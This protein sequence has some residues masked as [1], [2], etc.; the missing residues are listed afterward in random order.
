MVMRQVKARLIESRG[1]IQVA[2]IFCDRWDSVSFEEEHENSGAVV[3]LSLGPD[4]RPVQ[5]RP[6]WEANLEI[7]AVMLI[8]IVII[9]R[10]EA[11]WS[12]HGLHDDRHEE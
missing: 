11:K 1:T 4:G 5:P 7:T 10:N 3:F 2:I 12:G 6:H 8:T 9:V